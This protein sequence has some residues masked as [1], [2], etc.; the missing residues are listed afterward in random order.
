MAN[1]QSKW[2]GLIP[3]AVA[4]AAGILL[5]TAEAPGQGA[6]PGRFPIV[7][8]WSHRYV[9][10]TNASFRA[11]TLGQL[12][13]DPRLLAAWAQRN[14]VGA[15]A[16]ASAPSRQPWRRTPTMKRDWA[17][18]LGNNVDTSTPLPLEQFPAMW[19]ADITNPNCSGDFVVFGIRAD[20][21]TGQAN[22]VAFNN[23][24]TGCSGTVPSVM[25]AY[26]IGDTDTTPDVIRTSP[27]LSLNGQEV[28]FVE[29]R[30]RG[31]GGSYFHVLKWVPGQGTIGNPATPGNG[32]SWVRSV[33][34]SAGDGNRRSSPFV[35]YW[36][37]VAF[38]G[39]NNGVLYAIGPVFGQSSQTALSVLGSVTVKS[40]GA[41]LTSPVMDPGQNRL[42]ISDGTTLYSYT[43]TYS[44][45][46]VN[47]SLS[48]SLQI[49]T[50]TEAV[51][52]SALVDI[53][54]QRVFW[55]A[56]QTGSGGLT[57][58][59]VIETD[60]GLGNVQSAQ[61][62][63]D[64][65]TVIRSGAFDDA[66]YSNSQAGQLHVCGKA[67]GQPRL[68]TFGFQNGLW[69]TNPTVNTIA[70]NTGEC[71]PLTTFKS[72]TQD[73]LFLGFSA[74]D[75]I[76]MWNIPITSSGDV[77]DATASGY[78]GGSAGIIVDNRASQSDYNNI[79]FQTPLASTACGNTVCAVKL[80]QSGLQ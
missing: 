9:V 60:Y 31:G 65:T 14:L 43:V 27:V 12:Q 35:D 46:S 49:S 6:L 53:D 39:A 62:G 2:V 33:R 34:Y 64:S 61:I 47:F 3:L 18:S 36:H 1:R 54:R 45:G 40:A 37:N 63:E 22:I 66:H 68:Y 32:G 26:Y 72:D 78:N 4:A 10:Y 15:L 48:G 23:L 19:G 69:Q 13:R 42:F 44:N 21:S 70:T 30:D 29:N 50:D 24:Y 56:R 71:S 51:Q 59:R 79:Y 58:A 52:D 16:S 80:T 73:R 77:P 17:V 75:Q 5:V 38:V 57:G 76:Q 28:A 67:S 55:F 25:W 20:S 7:R 74:S 11:A 41:Y 8:D